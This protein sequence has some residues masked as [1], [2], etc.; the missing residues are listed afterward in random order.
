MIPTYKTKLPSSNKSISFRPFLVKEEKILLL[1]QQSEDD[2]G[3]MDAIAKVIE[4]CV[5]DIADAKSIPLVD[6]EH[7]FLQIRAKSVGEVISSIFTCPET[8]EDINLTINIPDIKL[9]KTENHSNK[10]K[11]Q[12]N[13]I[14]S[15]LH[16]TINSTIN[17]DSTNSFYDIL[18][19]CISTIQTQNEKIDAKLLSKEEVSEFIDN[20]TVPQ[21]EKIL[22]F[23]LDSPR[24]EYKTKYTTSDE[25]ERE[26]ILSGLSDFFG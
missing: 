7:L 19:D 12:D 25:I 21:F 17:Q 10:I 1:A 16:P 15:M 4:A 20:L 22:D 11:I 26:V 14:I 6:V 24:L 18:I 5:E 13:I 2:S 9:N 8:G 3:M 23:F